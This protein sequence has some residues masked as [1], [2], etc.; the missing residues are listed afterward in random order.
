MWTCPV[1]KVEVEDSLSLCPTCGYEKSS[2]SAVPAPPTS[3]AQSAVPSDNAAA[4][5]GPM[6]WHYSGKAF[7]FCNLLNWLTTLAFVAVG[8]YL[9]VSGHIGSYPMIVWLALLAV[10]AFFW[11]WFFVSYWYKT[12]FIIYRLSEAHL[13][14]EKGL[15]KR[16][17]DTME[18]IGIADLKM[19]QT[20]FDRV[21]NGGV[22]TVLVF[23]VSDKTDETLK[24]EGLADP[25]DVLEKIDNAR[26]KLRGRGFVQM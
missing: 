5:T 3:P 24:M 10:P 22:G 20:L 17:I 12:T 19:E 2:D 26:R 15:F 14:I 11:I 7:R 18:L 21:V 25:R 8:I 13:Y 4:Q 1:C 16:T 6:I 9:S 23:S